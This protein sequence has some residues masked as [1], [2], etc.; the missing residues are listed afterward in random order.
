MPSSFR[1]SPNIIAGSTDFGSSQDD[2]HKLTGSV[3]ITGSLSV[4]GVSITGGGGGG[5][6]IS[7]DGSTANGV[8]TFKDADEATVESNLTFDGS[9]L[10]VAGDVSASSNISASSFYGSAG[11]LSASYTAHDTRNPILSKLDATGKINAENLLLYE[12]EL[13]HSYFYVCSNGSTRSPKLILDHGLPTIRPNARTTLYSS[14][15]LTNDPFYLTR[16]ISNV[17]YPITIWNNTSD[18]SQ[19]KVGIN[20]VYPDTASYR[21][22]VSGSSR[23]QEDVTFMAGINPQGSAGD[24]IQIGSNNGAVAI[25][26][27]NISFGGTVLGQG[28]Q[29]IGPG[30]HLRAIAAGASAIGSGSN[31]IATNSMALGNIG[32]CIGN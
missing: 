10:T 31:A 28:S 26:S 21:F 17:Y 13:G 24:S 18:Q 4:N 14:D 8:A 11:N 25:G 29:A 9:T 15:T 1:P 6:G 16:R 19:D 3:T 2:G 30:S 12:Y 22:D 20:L 5:G 32:V 23:F 27:L 7:W